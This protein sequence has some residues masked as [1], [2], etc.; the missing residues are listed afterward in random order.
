MRPGVPSSLVGLEAFFGP[1][2]PG[3]PSFPSR[4]PFLALDRILAH[5]PAM[6]A[7]LEAHHSPLARLASDHLPLRAR[8]DLRAAS[9]ALAKAA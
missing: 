9:P 3:Q 1:L 6:L 5:P 7:G 8:I 4:L 2:G